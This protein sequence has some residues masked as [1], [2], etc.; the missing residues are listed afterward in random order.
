MKKQ[1]TLLSIFILG[2]F[3]LQSQNSDWR[4]APLYKESNY[5]EIVSK[6]KKALKNARS[7]SDRNSRKKIKQFERWAN[8]WKD[9]I[10]PD[11][12]FV[13][14]AH[15]YNEWIKENQRHSNLRRSRSNS[16]TLVGPVKLPKSS[17]SFY[18]GMGRINTVA[19]NGT[20]TQTMYVGTPGGG[21]WK[22]TDGGKNWSAKGD[23]F[24]N[25]GVSD[26]VINPTNTN[27]LYLA[28]GDWDGGQNRSLGV[29]KSIDAGE[30]WKTTGLTFTLGQ[31]NKISKLLIDPNNP[32]TIFATTLNSIKRSTD[33]GNSWSDV[34][35]ENNATFNDIEYKIG[36]NTII[37]AT[38]NA[39]KFYISTNNGSSWSVASTPSNDRIDFALTAKD[40]NLILTVDN[41]GVVRKSTN[42]GNSWTTI[43][44]ISSYASQG[45]YNI[46]IA[47]SPLDTNLILVGGMEGWR[48]KN[49]GT[50]W[51]KYL[52]GYWEAGSPYF[53]VH[54]DHHDM[55]FIPG[56]NIAFS[57]NDGGIF[58]GDASKDTK[59]EDLSEG[60][61]I[62]QYYNV[63]G[64]PKDAGKLI[65]G[66]QD[67][68]I[69]IY[70]GSNG[71]KGENPGS[72][73]VEG[74]WD[75]SNSNIAWTCSQNGG[76]NR[77]LD[78]FATAAQRVDTPGGAPFVWELEI[79]PTNPQ[80]I[81]GG[82]SDIYKSTNRGD[83]WTNLN[84]GVGS[85]E[86]ISISPSNPNVI[87]VSGQLGVKKTIN[88]G[89]SWTN[90]NLP[91]GGN[92]KSIEVHPTKPEEVYIAY[93]GYST[94]KVYKS[95]NGGT[96]W[97]NITGSLPNIPTHK[98][99]YKTGS[100]D[101][102]LFLATDLGVYYRTN[103]KN[104]WVRLGKGL[105]N[106]IVHDLEIHYGT[107]K[108]RAATYGRGVWE[109]SIEA[110][111]L[112]T[113]DNKLPN[114]AVN[115]YPN[116]TNNKQFTIKLNNLSGTSNVTIYNIIGG[117]VKNFK[118][119]NSSKQ[120]DLNDFSRG[121]YLVNIKNNG[122]TITKK[123]I[124]R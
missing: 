34:F 9:R 24:P 17:V 119:A 61:A 93:S 39:G 90:V 63:S 38:S 107:E 21:I 123:L 52:D 5:F 88:G 31:N 84:S 23:N 44:T 42:Q 10:K 18:P 103:S 113:E 27:I 70:D 121:L 117:V 116:P 79:H 51:E 8:F 87:Y 2:S 99:I 22:T 109:T 81:F 16:W 58:K 82:F 74:L 47:V 56:T 41:G 43:S 37:Y 15:N 35:T 57:T 75:Y 53:Y 14:A 100:S 66:A 115:L 1:I 72:D 32:N 76:M 73:G 50:T 77:T 20:D 110:S 67:N 95:D 122:K 108:L 49:G 89:S 40:P 92:V 68:D 69:A 104:D 114:S 111:A 80:T 78:G 65:M 54:S 45:G 26:I 101:G 7:R 83:T 124:V 102:E 94:G 86:F 13:S 25:M 120:V 85:I 46:T 64:T 112:G 4:S 48:S 118:L 106:V 62:T 97:T 30:T 71:F 91:Q 98:I 36:S 11:G 19:F 55:M 12:S 28:T 29:L 3:T 105:P 59:W 60:I 33:G 6:N 96:N